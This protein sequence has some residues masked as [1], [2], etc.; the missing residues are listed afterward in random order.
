MNGQVRQEPGE[1]LG[2]RK[3]EA[4]YGHIPGRGQGEAL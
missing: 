3:E 2:N 4:G 1:G